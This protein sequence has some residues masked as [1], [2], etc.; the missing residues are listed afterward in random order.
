M[1]RKYPPL[2]FDIPTRLS[3]PPRH[4]GAAAAPTI[5]TTA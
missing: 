3:F 2:P 5:P 1:K 4:L